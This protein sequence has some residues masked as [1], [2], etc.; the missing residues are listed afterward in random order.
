ME[1]TA[2]YIKHPA[3]TWQV[4]EELSDFLGVDRSQLGD[5]RIK[6]DRWHLVIY[7]N[8]GGHGPCYYYER[9]LEA[10]DY[11]NYFWLFMGNDMA[12]GESLVLMERILRFYW[13]RSI[14]AAIGDCASADRLPLRGGNDLERM[15]WAREQFRDAKCPPVV[16]DRIGE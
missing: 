6:T 7:D 1:G 14:P 4:L 9:D 2:V 3:K 11:F 5:L 12:D 8:Q 15:F 16:P 13:T 10:D